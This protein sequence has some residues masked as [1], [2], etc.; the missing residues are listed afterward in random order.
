MSKKSLLPCTTPSSPAT[1]SIQ[2]PSASHTPHPTG[3]AA[4]LS[5]SASAL[6]RSILACATRNRPTLGNQIRETV[7]LWNPNR[8][9]AVR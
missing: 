2:R 8:T 7:F 5:L 6:P 4:P 3:T 1:N 9:Q